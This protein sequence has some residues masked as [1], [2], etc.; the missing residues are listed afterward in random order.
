M[1]KY[2]IAYEIDRIHYSYM[3]L[4]LSALSYEELR[5]KLYLALVLFAPHRFCEFENLQ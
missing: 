1:S 4:M 3:G 5:S 2:D